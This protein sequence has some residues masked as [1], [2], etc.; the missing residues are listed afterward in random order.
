MSR[1]VCTLPSHFGNSFVS[2]PPPPPLRTRT[3]KGHFFD[4][5]DKWLL[6]AAA[7]D[8]SSSS[9]ANNSAGNMQLKFLPAQPFARSNL[10]IIGGM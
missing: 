2:P 6:L 1:R 5:L 3:H 10:T 8:T 9:S 7:N 4:R